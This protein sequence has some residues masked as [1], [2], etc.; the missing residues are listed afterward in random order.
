MNSECVKTLD[1]RSPTGRPLAEVTPSRGFLR[2]L[3]RPEEKKSAPSDIDVVFV[4]NGVERVGKEPSTF[5]EGELEGEEMIYSYMSLR[6]SKL[7]G[8]KISKYPCLTKS[9][10]QG[11]VIF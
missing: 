2:L 9:L 5:G 3:G 11:T 7:V 10:E 1:L 8:K 4:M 6:R